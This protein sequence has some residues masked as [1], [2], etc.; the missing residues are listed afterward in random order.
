MMPFALNHDNFGLSDGLARCW[1]GIGRGA[2]NLFVGVWAGQD[3]S[4]AGSNLQTK[5]EW[6]PKG[7]GLS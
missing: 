4:D 6:I 7:C 3:V 5:T 1:A 2:S